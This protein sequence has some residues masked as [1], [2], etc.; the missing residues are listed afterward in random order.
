MEFL[1]CHRSHSVDG[2]RVKVV[3]LV[4]NF[5]MLRLLLL[6]HVAI[7]VKVHIAFARPLR[8]QGVNTRLACI[9]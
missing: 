1:F 6:V 3:G 2:F 8:F 4:A 9:T 7:A 5:E